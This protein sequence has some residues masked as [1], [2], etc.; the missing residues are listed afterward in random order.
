MKRAECEMIY[1]K[2][3]GAILFGNAVSFCSNDVTESE[4]KNKARASKTK[5][6]L[7]IGCYM[8]AVQ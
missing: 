4:E 5:D 7:P 3:T 8:Y 1:Q 2:N 6:V